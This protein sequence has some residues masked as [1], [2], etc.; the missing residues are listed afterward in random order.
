MITRRDLL[1]GLGVGSAATLLWATGCVPSAP[2][3]RVADNQ[4]GD[5]R[6]WLR[7]AVARLADHA[8]E[9]AALAVMRRR[10]T[11]VIDVLGAGVA[12]GREDGALLAM[13]A[14]DGRWHELATSV[15]SATGVA[16]AADALIA[17]AGTSARGRRAGVLG[18]GPPR[19]F[20]AVD[21]PSHGGLG[22]PGA[23]DS[24]LAR[25]STM[26]AADRTLTSRIV[27]AAG[28]I[29]VDDATVWSVAPGHDLAQRIVRVRRSATRVAWNGTR[30]VVSEVARGWAGPIDH[31]AGGE[32]DGAALG[33]ATRDAL[34]LMTPG[35]FAAGARPVVLDPSLLA[36]LFDAIASELLTSTAARRP[37]VAARLA[38]GAGIG[39]ELVTVTDDPTAAGAYGG[40]AFDDDGA[41]AAPLVLIDRGHVA[42][43]LADRAGAEALGN[44]A[45]AG[46]GRRAGHLGAIAPTASHLRVAAG[47][48]ARDALLGDDGMIL[49]GGGAVSIDASTG[50][51]TI[52]AAR[53]RELRGGRTT[54]RV[55]ANV[56]LVGEVAALLGSI[57]AL[58]A[59][60]E[61]FPIRDDVDGRPRWRSLEVPWARAAGVVRPRR[62]SQ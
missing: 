60:T 20:G 29:D 52:A 13:R 37:E 8:T 3:I 26:V 6:G 35:D 31:P 41:I 23:D 50:Q 53:A 42:A 2:A 28:A 45:P 14:A 57:T 19:T 48:V 40:F 30:P 61:M 16:A 15:L 46:R 59:D 18:F 5:I 27:Y 38:L 1:R 56:E 58:S 51:V 54:G 55:Y 4:R 47:A 22:A 62:R 24:L 10:T 44:G 11:A 32:L 17:S 39:G 9:V 34:E 12:H 33:R 49:E 25:V 36:A 43:R 7:D 21:D